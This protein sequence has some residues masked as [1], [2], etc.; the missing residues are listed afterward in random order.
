MVA[1]MA[2]AP[3]KTAPRGARARPARSG[4]RRE[5]GTAAR[6]TE[7]L[8][9]LVTPDTR[10]RVMGLVDAHRVSQAAILREVVRRGLPGVETGLADGSIDP[11]TLP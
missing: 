3:Q 9:A 11:A 8:V 2:R 4:G 1:G 5:G 6:F 7:Q 10:E